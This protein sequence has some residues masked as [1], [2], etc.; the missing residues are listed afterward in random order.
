MS[1]TFDAATTAAYQAATTAAAR[2]AAIVASLTGTIS[3][4]VFNGSNVEMGAGTMAAPWSTA[5]GGV[6]TLGEVASFEV[7]TT[8]TPDAGWYIRFQNGDATRWVRGSF[9][10][11]GSGQDFTWSLATWEVG[12]AGNI[13]TA[14]IIASGNEAPVFTVAPTSAS[15]ASTGGTI[16]FT[17]ADPEG[18]SIFYSL[19]TTRA[20]ITISPTAGLV[21]VTAA[22]AGTSGNIVV[23]A[24]D[25]ILTASATCA[26][27]VSG[28]GTIKWHPGHGLKA[29]DDVG[30]TDALTISDRTAVYPYLTTSDRITFVFL[31]NR[32]GRSNPAG[33]TFTWTVIDALLDALPTGK[34]AI[35]SFDYKAFAGGVTTY[36][37][38]S[39]LEESHLYV[40]EGSQSMVAVW[41]PAVMDRFIA[42]IQAAGARYNSDPRVEG[43]SWSET[44]SGAFAALAADYS[45]SALATQLKRLYTA[46]A[47]A[48]PNT[49][50]FADMNSLSGE[51]GGATGLLEYAYQAGI[52]M[53]GPDAKPE[54]ANTIFTG[55]TSAGEVPVRDYRG[56]MA[57][58]QIASSPTLT[59][60]G[61]PANIIDWAQSHGVTHMPWY[62]T[63]GTYNWSSILAAINADTNWLNAC[64][65]VYGGTCD[66]S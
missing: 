64:P 66:G 8:G 59:E 21:T 34:R 57:N 2:A 14:T 44:A 41:R 5:S 3:V 22:A 65:I 56:L 48:F 58:H 51:L 11:L 37:C 62:P 42:Y 46:A 6:V 13:G 19:T 7:G 27:T 12:Q 49:N 35:L 38:P 4:K 39:D 53:A 47:A 52:G 9:G 45:R 20:G 18:G 32:W 63:H 1:A 16:Q 43:I 54:T 26:V 30:K 31:G 28:Y 10:L 55:V 40:I 25:G 60:E 36:L 15:I 24:S 29:Y 17:A 50:V 33:S 61:P 23:Q